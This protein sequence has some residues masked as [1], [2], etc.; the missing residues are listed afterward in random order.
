MDALTLTLTVADWKKHF[1]ISDF[2]LGEVLR[3]NPSKR[4]NPTALVTLSAFQIGR[5]SA[6]DFEQMQVKFEMFKAMVQ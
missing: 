2:Q 6:I 1:Q 3:L 5:Y 4:P